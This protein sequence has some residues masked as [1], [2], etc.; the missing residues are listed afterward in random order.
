MTTQKDS[1]KLRSLA[2]AG[3]ASSLRIG[4]EITAG[5]EIM[6][7]L[8]ARLTSRSMPGTSRRKRT[9]RE[10]KWVRSKNRRRSPSP[11][12]DLLALRYE[13]LA[14]RPSKVSLANLGRPGPLRPWFA[15]W[16]DTLPKVLGADALVRLRDAIVRAT[17]A[18][19]PGRRRA[20]RTRHQDR[21]R[22]RIW[23]TGSSAES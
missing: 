19:R 2:R 8:L 15:D 4:L 13:P 16:L 6:D 3:S 9:S 5:R 22:R 7:D 23:S 17:A 11:S 12:I 14:E 21:V 18:N 10:P 20:R 1:V